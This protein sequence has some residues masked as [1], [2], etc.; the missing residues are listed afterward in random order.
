MSCKSDLNL[1]DILAFKTISIA[2]VERRSQ[3]VGGAIESAN[4][5]YD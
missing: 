3:V 4:D 5:F 2:M 1:K